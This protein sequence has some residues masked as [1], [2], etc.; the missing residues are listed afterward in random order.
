MLNLTSLWEYFSGV[1]T[2]LTDTAFQWLCVAAVQTQEV[3][4]IS[5]GRWLPR[6]PLLA[7]LTSCQPLSINLIFAASLPKFRMLHQLSVSFQDA[8]STSIIFLFSIFFCKLHTPLD[9]SRSLAVSQHLIPR[10]CV[11]LSRRI[12]QPYLLRCSHIQDVTA[13][14]QKI[15]VQILTHM[16]KID[17]KGSYKDQFSVLV[18]GWMRGGDTYYSDCCIVFN[19]HKFIQH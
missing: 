14:V 17:S 3:W 7:A 5:Q 9:N 11:S 8:S 13:V 19:F 16:S 10:L 2:R 6:A 18:W 4:G 15:N 1:E 12:L